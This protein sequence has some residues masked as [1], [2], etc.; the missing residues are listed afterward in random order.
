MRTVGLLLALI[1]PVAIAG[2]CYRD[3]ASTTQT[4]LANK[5]RPPDH[6]HEAEDE[7]AF[8]PKESDVVVGLD[9]TALRS[10]PAWHEQIEPEL[11]Q[12]SQVEKNRQICGFDPWAPITHVT[13]GV[14]KADAGSEFLLTVAGGDAQQEIGCVLKQLGTEY[15]SH[16]DGDVTLI[17]K[18]SENSTIALSAVGRSHT[19]AFSTP[20]IDANRMHAQL[21]VGAPL[22]GSPAFMSIYESLEHGASLWFVINGQSSLFQSL[23]LGIRPRYIDGTIIVSDHY[24]WTTR[25]TMATAAEATQLANMLRGMS[26]QVQ[27]MVDKLD[28]HEENAVLHIDIVMTQPQVQTILKMLGAF[29]GP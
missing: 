14:R 2:G 6:S 4:P 1:A 24:V 16:P 22:R 19:I 3:S 13:L 25:I 15:T 26:A 18:A 12:S 23:S 8:L 21:S 20:G 10:S 5:Q 11:A 9:M 28:I 29:T 27:Q 7:L 17:S